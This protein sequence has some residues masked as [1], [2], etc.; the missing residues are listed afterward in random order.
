M[1]LLISL[2]GFESA[3]GK[4]MSVFFQLMKGKFDNFIEWPFNKLVTFVLIHQDNKNKHFKR[5]LEN[6][7]VTIDDQS[8]RKPVAE[9]NV[10]MGLKWFISHEELCTGGF[11]KNDTIY[12][13]CVIG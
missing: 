3:E 13:R 5:S 9:Y 12:I 4:F 7:L 10:F 1:R 8:F 2:N 11:I 6:P